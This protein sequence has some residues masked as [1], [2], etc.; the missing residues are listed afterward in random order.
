[1]ATSST[2]A[3]HCI[4]ALWIPIRFEFDFLNASNAVQNALDNA[5]IYAS[6]RFTVDES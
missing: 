2:P 5:L 4:I 6:T 1:M 3:R